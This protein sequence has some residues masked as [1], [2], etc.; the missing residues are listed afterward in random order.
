MNSESLYPPGPA[1]LTDNFTAPSPSYK[2]GVWIAT[3]SL[4]L[5]IALYFALTSWFGWLAWKFIGDAMVVGYGASGWWKGIALGTVAAFLTLFLVKALFFVRHGSADDDTPISA[6]DHPKLFA[7]LHQLADEAGAPRPH[8][9]YLSNRVNAAVFY[10][11][12]LLG[13]FIPA[14]K[15]LEIGLPLINAL[16]LS[17]LKAVLAHEF[18]HFCQGSMMVGR[19]VYIAQ[20]VATQII[21][22]RDIL[23]KF[24]R[25]LSQWDLRIAWVG[26]L[27]RL[28]VWSLRAVLDTAFSL[29]VL[30][31]RSLSREMEFHAD[32]VAVSL[33]GSD[34][35]VH[36]LHRLH[37][38][39]ECWERAL[40]MA[41]TEL[42]AGKAVTDIFVLQKLV[43][44]RMKAI[45]DDEHYDAPPELPATKVEEHR[46]FS[47]EDVSPPQMWATHPANHAR[48]E[49]AKSP[50][51]P[52]AEDTRA[53]WVLFNNPERLRAAVT[54][55]LLGGD[56]IPKET[57]QIDLQQ[58]AEQVKA[59]YS[60]AVYRQSYRGTYMGRSPV[61][62]VARVKE[63]FQI[64][65]S[66]I[67]LKA[68]LDALYPERLTDELAQWRNL[69]QE[70]SSLQALFDGHLKTTDG[71]IRH[72]GAVLKRKQI[73]DV[74]EALSIECDEA[75]GTI[76]QHDRKVRSTFSAAATAQ[77]DGWNG[78]YKG[79]VGLLHYADHS[80]ANVADVHGQLDNLWA[81]ANADGKIS[82]KEKKALL[83][84]CKDAWSV[85]S[86][87][88]A[89][90]SE[91]VLGAQVV[92][93]LGVERW[94]STLDEEFGLVEPSRDNIGDWLGA[95][96]SWLD[97]FENSFTGLRNAALESLLALEHNLQRAANQ[98]LQL[99]AA[100]TPPAVPQ[101]YA[102]L[103]PEAERKRQTR[104]GLWDR[105]QTADGFFPGL[106]R[107]AVA[108]AIV[109]GLS[110]AGLAAGGASV[111]IYNGLSTDVLVTIA[112]TQ[113]AVAALGTATASPP[114][115]PARIRTTNSTGE[116]IEDFSV[117]ADNSLADYVY[118]VAS[119]SPLVEWTA[120]YG[121]ASEVKN[122]YR[123]SPR[124]FEA[125]VDHLF[126]EPPE[127]IKIEGDGDVRTV[128][129]GFGEL[130]PD[131][132]V[133]LIPDSAIQSE[134][135]SPLVK[136]HVLWDSPSSPNTRGW[137]SLA[138]QLGEMPA[139]IEQ[140]LAMEPDNI[141]LRRL[142][143]DQASEELRMV[144]CAEHRRNAKAAPANLNWKYL[145]TRCIADLAERDQAFM[146]AH[147]AAPTHPWF[148]LAAGYTY[149]EQADWS[150]ALG[151]LEQAYGALPAEREII[152]QDLARLR[153]VSS[154]SIKIQ[155][156][157]LRGYDGYLDTAMLLESTEELAGDDYQTY[158]NFVHGRLRQAMPDTTKLDHD[159]AALVRRI[160]A[161]AG[162][163]PAMIE[164]AVQLEGGIGLDSDSI[165][166]AI[167]FA[168]RNQHNTD[169]LMEKADALLAED[170][171]LLRMLSS[172]LTAESLD[173]IQYEILLLGTRPNLRGNAYTMA[174]VALGSRAP[175][176]WRKMAQQLLFGLERPFLG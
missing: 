8:K 55:S 152:A 123:G 17:E 51:V 70:R 57:Q 159:G 133:D 26:W 170:A 158:Q 11:L 87:L 168:L 86:Q 46:V 169:E 171:A 7:F 137:L 157:D 111:T 43:A 100:P 59:H 30:A 129:S 124:W 108:G 19:W 6:T 126:E 60:K 24:L 165:W 142:E 155:M 75:R 76:C 82:G 68:E 28:V 144:I 164:A 25:G 36:A 95:C 175:A 31:Q 71:V 107:L 122:R 98:G 110:Y 41:S 54:L 103:I 166:T 154:N 22:R 85:M 112:D 18:G 140:R 105:F 53:G 117:E 44:G 92:K 118:N 119:A 106:G 141:M 156:D 1:N 113:V 83:V 131:E 62:E 58:T 73:P 9:V 77:S 176:E 38:A 135:L 102:T 48:E 150:R 121:D 42:A 64:G 67:D 61:R 116:L 74:L 63:L 66:K 115:G 162:A 21:H 173:K 99:K 65:S 138:S 16:T 90:K 35:I 3:L 78:Y 167:G 88:E 153:R 23:D 146:L 69:L 94:S 79:M 29:V 2:R 109:G 80:A 161:S 148:A 5:F 139:L 81:V 134:A 128:L 120:T 114:T 39:D 4:V 160:A 174:T 20:Q 15:N 151:A 72:R 10:N 56:Q 89:Q 145:A 172:T 49:N 47:N 12:S 52:A 45:L 147:E 136:A 33:T 40:G 104:L 13:L 101:Q 132:I 163:T 93:E 97:Y 27:M 127:E 125:E 91:V 32:K 14:K 96:D 84:V 143:H 149:A 50:Y 130:S 34:A 37:A